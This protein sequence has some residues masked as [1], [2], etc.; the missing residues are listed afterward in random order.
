MSELFDGET[1][2]F[3][4]IFQTLKALDPSSAN[5]LVQQK[6]EDVAKE[7]LATATAKAL[8]AAS[9]LNANPGQNEAKENLKTAL[10]SVRSAKERVERLSG[11]SPEPTPTGGVHSGDT[12]DTSDTS[13]DPR[14]LEDILLEW[15]EEELVVKSF[16]SD[17]LAV[18]NDGEEA[19]LEGGNN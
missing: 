11:S 18:R 8:V 10:E 3:A 16:T 4:S 6:L 12:S 13:E 17:D 15:S 19:L 2:G 1:K 9:A 7:E 5:D 14:T